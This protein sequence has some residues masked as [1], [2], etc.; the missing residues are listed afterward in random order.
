G[1]RVRNAHR[2][3]PNRWG[4]SR[5]VRRGEDMN[6]LALVDMGDFAPYAGAERIIEINPDP[7]GLR[8][9]WDD[10]HE[11]R[12]HWIWLRDHC[13]CAKCRH[14]ATR[15]RLFEIHDLPL[16]L[17]APV[18]RLETEGALQLLWQGEGQEEHVSRYDPA[19]L[20]R[21]AYDPAGAAAQQAPPRGWDASIAATL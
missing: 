18:V 15:E 5:N 16:P 9:K 12:F 14:P 21:R 19:W 7:T 1:S 13:A 17:A 20:R 6:A 2:S 11:T 3:T 8:V 4:G 10:G